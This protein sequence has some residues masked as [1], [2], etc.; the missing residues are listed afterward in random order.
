MIKSAAKNALVVAWVIAAEAGATPLQD[1]A[2]QT[3]HI[4]A[5]TIFARF[6][7]ESG[8]GREPPSFAAEIFTDQPG[9]LTHFYREMS[10]GQFELTGEVLPRRYASR[11]TADSYAD[12]EAGYGRFAREIIE[13]ADA[14]VD[15]S[16][17]DN[18]GPDGVP[19]SGDDDGYVDYIFIVSASAPP[20][21]IVGDATG[22]SRLGLSYD[23][24]SQDRALHGG[25]I[26]IQSK[27]GSVQRGK[28]FADAVGIMAHEFGHFL[29]LPDLY[30]LDRGSE[31]AHDSGGIGY[32]GLMAHGI[33]GWDEISGPNPFCA[34]SLGQ[35]GWLGVNNQQLK[36]LSEDQDD[37]V[38]ADVNAGG[39]VY[40]LPAS[41]P[42]E[43]FFL[44][45]FR[46]RQHSYYERNLPGEGLLIWRINPNRNGNNM[47]AIKQVDLVCADGLFRDAGFPLGRTPAPFS[48]RDN[49]DFWAHDDRYRTDF[50][51]NLGDATDV[52]DGEQFTDF[53]AA[54]NP[55]STTGVSVTRIRREGDRMVADL[56]LQDHRRAGPITDMEIWRDRIEIVGDVTVLPGGHLDVRTGAEVLVGPDALA[57][58]ADTARVELIVYG[59]LIVGIS[60]QERI[61]FRSAAAD[62]QP[63]D[64]QGIVLQPTASAYLRSVLIDHAR[65]GL[66]AEKL[67]HTITLEN[68]A[69]RHAGED[70]IRLENIEEEVVFDRVQVEESGG[71]GIWIA[72]AG[73]MRI[74]QAELHANG[75]AGL[76]REGGY[77][78][79]LD[80]RFNNNGSAEPEEANLVLGRGASGK[81]VGNSFAGGIGIYCV[82][83]R[84]VEIEDN[85][86]YNHEVGLW[87]RSARPRI[88]RNQFFRNALALRVEG[89]VVPARLVLNGVQEGEQLIDN[90]TDQSLQA[91][92]NW[93]GNEDE[94]WIEARISGD[95]NWQPF[96]NFDSRIPLNFALGQNYPNPFNEGTQI[97]YQIGI[98]DPIVAGQTM[99]ELEVRTLTGGLVR[100]LVEGLAAPGLY[101][102]SWDGR[103]ER[104][105]RVASGMY[106]YVLRIG[107]IV[108][109]KKMVFVK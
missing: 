92:N 51:G 78:S 71:V 104:G 31:P 8:L 89:S 85:A 63:G 96:L 39:D 74:N 5:L 60:G 20:G 38:F 79:L 17:Y 107:P 45:E 97:D 34:W 77:L 109:A 44:V 56:K 73:L 13:A 26:Q 108:H 35:L 80:S 18:D 55:A 86:L 84:E 61:V 27:S 62:P 57:A 9:S 16:R 10:R 70:G 46:S 93:W 95:V 21:F 81:V 83:T 58:G 48:G 23:F 30:D 3:G 28:N 2:S 53:W 59:D 14:D 94:S 98:N 1:I 88:V 11:S 82:E 36:V 106:Y 102:T 40:L 90:Q 6:A 54:S 52:F 87:S 32:W 68:V 91:I 24:V 42:A 50:G 4:H 49:L 29:G 19:N 103:D 101:S 69:I 100:H 7:N 25:F 75:R 22:V 64:W 43:H 15:F 105:E 76:W 67:D 33:R 12:M 37:V 47:E 41:A 72:G 65:Y 99:V 66:L